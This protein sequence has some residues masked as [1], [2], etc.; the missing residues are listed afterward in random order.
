MNEKNKDKWL[1]E[2]SMES[3]RNDATH[4]LSPWLKVRLV[5]EFLVVP[6]DITFGEVVEGA[7]STLSSVEKYW[8][9]L[10]A[11]GEELPGRLINRTN[12]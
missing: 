1:G 2:L 11:A 3:G 5:V 9:H 7:G 4:L 6:W 10:A 12:F 8:L